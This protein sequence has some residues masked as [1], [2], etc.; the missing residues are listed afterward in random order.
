MDPFS[1][2]VGL[3]DQLRGENGCEWD[4]KQTV[5]SF[6]TFLV[7]EVYEVIDA[8]EKKDYK[9][10]QEELGDLL[11]HIVFI[12][13]ICKEGGCFD[14]DDVIAEVSD[15]MEY[16][17]PHVFSRDIIDTRPLE[18]RWE[19]LKRNEKDDYTP[20]S[21]LP[22]SLPALLRAY[23]ISKRAAR[24]GFDWV[25]MDGVY[26]KVDEELR[27][28]KE[29]EASRDTAAIQEEIGDLLFTIVNISRFHHIDPEDA[30]RKTNE[31]FIRRFGH[32]ERNLGDSHSSQNL[33]L[34]A[35]EKLWNEAKDMEKKG[36]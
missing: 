30:L 2:L 4:K 32:I 13:R 5:D 36:G 29:A 19:E 10:L 12:S 16:R 24:V 34:S 9:A 7:E 21:G 8:I 6:G 35:M 23:L 18:I 1:R 33:S 25:D 11:F 20:V 28:L 22:K 14:I 26:D 31:K 17:H 15:K 27:E 3:M